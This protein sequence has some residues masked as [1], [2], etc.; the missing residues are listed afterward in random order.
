MWL[1]PEVFWHCCRWVRHITN[2]REEILQPGSVI[3]SSQCIY[4]SP[5][6]C[7]I[8]VTCT[9]S[10]SRNQTVL[11]APLC[12]SLPPPESIFPPLWVT[13]CALVLA[14]VS[15]CQYSFSKTQSSFRN[16][17]SY[18][19]LQGRVRFCCSRC[20]DVWKEARRAD[21][22]VRMKRQQRPKLHM[23]WQKI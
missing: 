3:G 21:M 19:N 6:S 11:R 10:T 9:S 15:S 12:R 5:I 14:S 20:F 23:Q 4:P 16:W 8:L 7:S 17:L 2:S 13:V 22:M 18:D 1:L